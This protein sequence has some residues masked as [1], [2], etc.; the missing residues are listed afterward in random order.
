MFDIHNTDAVQCYNE[1][2][3][4]YKRY[5]NSMFQSAGSRT[6]LIEA[7]CRLCGYNVEEP[8]IQKED[9][10]QDEISESDE[11]PHRYKKK[12]HKHR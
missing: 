4:H 1:M 9:N 11:E 6:A 12:K 7:A 3:Q 10:K 2:V 5:A 8:E